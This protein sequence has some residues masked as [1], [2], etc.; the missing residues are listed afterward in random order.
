[1]LCE[2]QCFVFYAYV[3]MSRVSNDVSDYC[4]VSECF[5][6]KWLV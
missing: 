4:A 6:F 3:F 5:L 2:L 1:M